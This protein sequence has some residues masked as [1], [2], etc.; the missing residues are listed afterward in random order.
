M[1]EVIDDIVP[2]LPSFSSLAY[3]PSAL[4]AKFRFKEPKIFEDEGDSDNMRDES[5]DNSKF[6]PESPAKEAVMFL[7]DMSEILKSNVLQELDVCPDLSPEYREIV[8]ELVVSLII[9]G[10]LL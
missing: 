4:I 7:T 1:Q 8:A 5:H 9:F 2:H 10:Y 6:L 3:P